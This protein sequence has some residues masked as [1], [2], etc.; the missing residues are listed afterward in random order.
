MRVLY[1][2]EDVRAEIF[3]DLMALAADEESS[4]RLAAFD[5]IINLME[6]M[7]S[8]ESSP[9]YILSCLTH[10]IQIPL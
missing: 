4:V 3:P 2:V 10:T 8:G 1:R 6:L 5:T 9:L 7:D